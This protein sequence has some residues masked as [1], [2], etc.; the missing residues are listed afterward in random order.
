MV[1]SPYWMAPEVI[2]QLGATTA[3]DIW[4]V[5]CV[6]IEL[7]DGGRPPYHFLD[8]MPALFRIVND[9][10]PPIPVGLSPSAR[11]FLLQCFQKDPNLRISARKLLKHP[12]LA[13]TRQRPASE[14]SPHSGAVEHLQAW[15]RALHGVSVGPPKLTAISCSATSQ[16]VSPQTGPRCRG[17][18]SRSAQLSHPSR[19]CDAAVSRQRHSRDGR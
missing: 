17:R 10:C 4:S 15:N 6:V 9:D 2:D 12:W 8:P 16:R 14:Q 5:G 13:T 19:T 11:D 3:S 7:L 18:P 1:G